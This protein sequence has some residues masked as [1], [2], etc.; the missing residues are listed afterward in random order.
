[1][2]RAGSSC[3]KSTWSC[4][5]ITLIFFVMR[6]INEQLEVISKTFLLFYS[7][8]LMH[9]TWPSIC[10]ISE[11]GNYTTLKLFWDWLL[12]FSLTNRTGDIQE[13]KSEVRKKEIH[14]ATKT[15]EREIVKIWYC[16]L[17]IYVWIINIKKSLENRFIFKDVIFWFEYNLLLL[18]LSKYNKQNLKF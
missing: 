2:H 11:K 14:F 18:Y 6:S 4:S 1:M 17:N 12:V 5:Q 7:D 8:W 13:A 10:S 16:F 3:L 15:G 9:V